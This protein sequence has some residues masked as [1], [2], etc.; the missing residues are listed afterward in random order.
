MKL[1]HSVGPDFLDAGTLSPNLPLIATQLTQ[2][3]SSEL[4]MAEQSTEWDSSV[5]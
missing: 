5:F 3:S 4:G 2:L 1:W